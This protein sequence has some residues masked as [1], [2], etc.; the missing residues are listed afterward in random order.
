MSSGIV[1]TSDLYN[2]T[3]CILPQ[4]RETIIPLSEILYMTGIFNFFFTQT[5]FIKNVQRL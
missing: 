2:Y 4:S 1:R 3:I 5:F